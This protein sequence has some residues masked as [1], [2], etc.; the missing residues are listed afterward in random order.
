MGERL[1]SIED[2]EIYFDRCRQEA[3][4]YLYSFLQSATKQVDVIGAINRATRATL[5]SKKLEAPE[6]LISSA[7]NCL[8]SLLHL[9]RNL[10]DH[11]I[12]AMPALVVRYPWQA[13]QSCKEIHLVATI[14]NDEQIII[15]DPTPTAGYSYGTTRIGKLSEGRLTSPDVT[16]EGTIDYQLLTPMEFD[17]IAY[18]YAYEVSPLAATQVSSLHSLLAS[19][20]NVPSYQARLLH[21]L[22]KYTALEEY[23]SQLQS[24]SPFAMRKSYVHY[25]DL[26]G[27][28][29]VA[30]HTH[31]ELAT[32]QQ[33]LAAISAQLDTADSIHNYAYWAAVY[34]DFTQAVSDAYFKRLTPV[35]FVKCGS[36][37]P[38][39]DYEQF[40]IEH[41][42]QAAVSNL[43]MPHW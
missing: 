21:L 25:L 24:M 42:P 30:Q 38:I 12:K 10:H 32:K 6:D 33:M 40:I 9:Q 43:Y 16:L 28:H 1:Q 18:M 23:R 11:G 36:I 13:Q 29:E 31:T 22:F 26:V 35:H 17:A 41:A 19:L 8:G 7:T 14:F 37:N 27:A 34:G 5:V 4:E 20:E 3:E 15:A 39:L 2:G